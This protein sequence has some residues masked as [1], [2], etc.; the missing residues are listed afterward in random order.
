M[1]SIYEISFLYL[2]YYIYNIYITSS[3][4]VQHI[5]GDGL[6]L[7]TSSRNQTLKP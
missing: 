1:Y 4:S 2:I 7:T 3:Y 6:R 5:N